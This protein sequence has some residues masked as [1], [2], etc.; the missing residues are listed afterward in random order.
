M[1]VFGK[2]DVGK[3]RANNQDHFVV[4]RDAS[5]YAIADGM[6]GHAAGEVASEIAIE[7]L[8]EHVGNVEEAGKNGDLGTLEEALVAAIRDGNRRICD[9][10]VDHEE[11]R[12]MGTTLVTFWRRDGK[13]LI[14][15]V[16]DS[17]AYRLRDGKLTRLTDDHSWVEEQVRRGV[18]SDQEA[19]NH[20]M[21][22][23][24]TRAMGTPD[25]LDVEINHDDMQSGDLYLLCSDGLNSMIGDDEIRAT[26]ARYVDDPEAACDGLIEQA[27]A[28]GGDDNITVIVIRVED[29]DIV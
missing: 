17:R 24:V 2:T 9:S 4:D 1:K 7:T 22:N 18:L 13:A 26:L 10:V 8:V 12:G 29:D 25:G 27:N 14:G 5:F 19:V 20:P 11:R 28:K 21:R 15:H 3:R 16:G 6:G 23:V